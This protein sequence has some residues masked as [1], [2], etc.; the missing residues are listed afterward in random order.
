MKLLL[1]LFN[2]IFRYIS[3]W[4]Y[5]NAQIFFLCLKTAIF[6]AVL[7]LISL[8]DEK[9]DFRPNLESTIPSFFVSWKEESA[10]RSARLLA[11]KETEHEEAAGGS[12]RLF[13]SAGLMLAFELRFNN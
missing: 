8:S 5:R 13:C 12:N 6:N 11:A 9:A 10:N 3:I 4:P 2:F 1:F 7:P